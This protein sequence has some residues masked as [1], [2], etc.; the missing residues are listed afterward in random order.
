MENL[1]K[2]PFCSYRFCGGGSGVT[3]LFLGGASARAARAS[4]GI[5]A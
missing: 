1:S 3:G 5:V 4:A 2:K